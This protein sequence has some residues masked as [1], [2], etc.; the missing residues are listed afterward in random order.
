MIRCVISDLGKVIIF[1]DNNIFG[2]LPEDAS[3]D[4]QAWASFVGSSIPAFSLLS[5]AF[6]SREKISPTKPKQ[7]NMI[8]VFVNSP[9][10]RSLILPAKNGKIVN[11]I[12][13]MQVIMPKAVPK[14]LSSTMMGIIGQRAAGTK[15]KDTP[16]MIIGITGWI[17]VSPKI[18]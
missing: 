4:S 17:W 15:E 5:A 8:I 12:F 11:P 1:F 10:E 6:S 7:A 13:W 9:P 2:E 3:P 16:T 14:R 18:E